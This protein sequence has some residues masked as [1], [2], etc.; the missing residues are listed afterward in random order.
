MTHSLG[1]LICFFLLEISIRSFSG[2]ITMNTSTSQTITNFNTD[3]GV[4]SCDI[5]TACDV[6][7]CCDS[8]CD[9]AKV[10]SWTTSNW[11]G[12]NSV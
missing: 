9:T 8:N 2:P 4:C 5:S 3:L 12:N 10:D 7:C 1:V 6:F 11:C